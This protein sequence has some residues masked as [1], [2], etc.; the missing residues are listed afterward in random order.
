[1]IV[2][3]AT[4]NDY[5]SVTSMLDELWQGL[6]YLPT[7]Y[8]VFLQTQHHVFYLAEINRRVVTVEDCVTKGRLG[9]GQGCNERKVAG[10]GVC[11]GCGIARRRR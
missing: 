4:V 3:R 2:R 8:H 1:M 10:R 5:D 6:D 9:S 7:L 11:S